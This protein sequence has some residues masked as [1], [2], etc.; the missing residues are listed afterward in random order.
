MPVEP[1]FRIHVGRIVGRR[2]EHLDLVEIHFEFFRQQHGMCRVTALADLDARQD[3]EDLVG[4]RDSDE[5]IG[6]E[7]GNTPAGIERLL[8][9]RQHP[10]ART[11]GQYLTAA[12]REA[13]HEPAAPLQDLATID[14]Q[15]DARRG[16]PISAQDP[17]AFL[18]AARMRG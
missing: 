12:Q 2:I 8:R 14:D 17:A 13:K 16:G 7:P 10:G 5:G 1:Q 18:M 9:R 6:R 4:V 3:Q 15:I 11:G